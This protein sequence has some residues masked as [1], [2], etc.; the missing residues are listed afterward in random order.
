MRD[1]VLQK[2]IEGKKNQ[3]LDGLELQ[4]EIR[5]ETR[6]QKPVKDKNTVLVKGVTFYKTEDGIYKEE[7]ERK[8]GKAKNSK[9]TALFSTKKMQKK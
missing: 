5:N 9:S 4:Q 7:E 3:Q 6:V 2:N 1:V 8:K